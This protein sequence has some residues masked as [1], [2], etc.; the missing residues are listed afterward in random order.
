L[1]SNTAI[2]QADDDYNGND[3]FTFSADDGGGGGVGAGTISIVVTATND[4]PFV[5]NAIADI[6]VDED[7][8]ATLVDLSAT[9][10]DPDLAGGGEQLMLSISSAASPLATTTLTGTTLTILCAANQN[11]FTDITVRATDNAGAFAED[12]FRV[13]INPIN[14]PPFAAGTLADLIRAEDAPNVVLDL[15]GVFDDADVATNAD[16][17]TLS[18]S[19]SAA[20][21]VTTALSS[22]SLTLDLQ[23]NQHGAAD[24]TVRATDL[25]GQ[26]AE[27]AFRVTITPVNDPPIAEAGGPYIIDAGASL[28][29][30]AG[31]STD[32]DLIGGRGDVLSFEWDL[33]GDSVF[34]A[35]SSPPIGGKFVYSPSRL[36]ELGITTGAYTATLRVTDGSGVNSIDTTGLTVFDN[37]P[38]AALSAGPNPSGLGQAVTLDAS[39]S[40][41]G[42]PDRSIVRYDFTFGDGDT[43]TETPAS[44][45]DGI[46]DGKTIHIY[47]AFGSFAASVVVTDDN[48][49]AKSA[50]ASVNV[51]VDQGNRAPVAV[52]GGP[53][54]VDLG[55]T[56]T[57]NGMGSSDPDSTAGDSIVDYVWSINGG[58]VM[59]NGATPALTIAQI[60]ALGPGVVNVN[61]TV[62]DS[63]GA[64]GS[65]LTSLSI[66]DNRPKPVLSATPN[67]AA[68]TQSV[69]FNAGASS[70]GRPDRQIVAYVWDFGDGASASGITVTHTYAAFGDYT[71]TLTVTDNNGP[72]KSATTSSTIN[73]NQGNRAPVAAPNGPY[74]VELGQGV[75]LDG[76]SSFDPDAALGDHIVSYSWNIG[77]LVLAGVMPALTAAQVNALGIGTFPVSLTVTDAFG[78]TGA[79]TTMLEITSP[80]Q[81]PLANA[82]GPYRF[83][84]GVAL[85]LDGSH[86]SDDGGIAKFEWDLNYDG[87]TFHAELAGSQ[88]VVSFHDEFAAR[89]IALR[90][91]DTAGLTSIAT[92][93][94]EITNAPPTA[95]DDQVSTDEDTE[96]AL[97]PAALL[98]NDSDAGADILSIT[99]FTQPPHGLVTKR[100]DGLIQY[101]PAPDFFGDDAFSYTI[102]DGDGGEAGAIVHITVK[103]MSDPPVADAGGPYLLEAG[104]NPTFNAGASSDPD[105]STLALAFAWDLNHDGQ[106]DGAETAPSSALHT[107]AWDSVADLGLG[108]HP[109]TL[110]VTDASGLSSTAETTLTI[111]DTTPPDT[112]II[113]ETNEY[114]T[115]R[116]ATFEF[117]SQLSNVRPWDGPIRF[118]VSLDGGA[119][120]P[121][122]GGRLDLVDLADGEHHLAARAVDASG[123]VDPTPAT[124]RWIVDR[125]PPDTSITTAP[126]RYINTT[127][128]SIHFAAQGAGTPIEFLYRLDGGPEVSTADGIAHFTGLTEGEHRF[129]VLAV[130][131]AGNRDQTPAEL[132]FGVDTR[133]PR[134]DF[135]L[136]DGAYPPDTNYRVVLVGDI[137]DSSPVQLTV[138]KGG[139]PQT[140][141]HTGSAPLSPGTQ[142]ITATA[143]DVAGNT[144]TLTRS[145]TVTGGGMVDNNLVIVGTEGPD[146]VVIRPAERGLEVTLNGEMHHFLLP[147]VAQVIVYGLGGNDILLAD[148]LRHRLRA[149]GGDGDDSLVGGFASDVLVGGE[150]N[151][152][153]YGGFGRDLLIG[154]RGQDQL[155]GR[156]AIVIG[157]TTA[158]DA[159]RQALDQI[160]A[161]W[162]D[163]TASYA[164]R[165]AKF[166]AGLGDD[167]IRLTTLPGRI[168]VFNDRSPDTLIGRDGAADWFFAEIGTDLTRS[169]SRPRR[170]I[171]YV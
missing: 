62:T 59:L 41:H 153:V 3:S 132:V 106:F 92:S 122:A 4:A 75:T 99:N 131:R 170:L 95:R 43:Y 50:S 85:M 40:S 107:F 14:D 112:L 10:G 45:P 24:I 69:L 70:H 98:A 130:D 110:R 103:P 67:P 7:S 9:F 5:V 86:S 30:D 28:E 94:L 133:A 100:N 123:N 83:A 46:F 66:Y 61:L 34:D 118:E 90:V 154:G 53:Y 84:E 157:G 136:P 168:T 78:L 44:A 36:A 169:P 114:S 117:Q 49:P 54:A 156:G 8:P 152:L 149:F 68:P 105:Q 37:R 138:T 82:G 151:D 74:A 159:N 77:G 127:E 42:R 104:S 76:G 15:A 109:I 146:S 71:V 25:A 124:F 144:T 19:S 171:P 22:T 113:T 101:T 73:V 96:L 63:F 150:G 139:V 125:S 72:P 51:T 65:A 32:A 128:A 135:S 27:Q 80:N 164:A 148:H 79:A 108:K 121:I 129:S 137:V 35:P 57:L 17:L 145:Y 167:K 81:T 147:A 120:A 160:V 52:A 165:R 48:S 16:T 116:Q 13:T 39:A 2:Y 143:T 1:P 166:A 126:A 26:F 91:T 111:V 33:N 93:T 102:G 60:N 12:T 134:I 88:P 23:P 119:F 89:S 142:V 158:Y 155:F 55:S 6:T 162:S 58:A 38:I 97:A 47:T 115:S 140:L 18:V 11:G 20:T 21:L 31:G 64:M 141:D 161:A 163:P 87:L 56:L 29:L